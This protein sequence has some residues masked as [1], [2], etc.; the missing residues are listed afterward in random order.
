MHVEHIEQHVSEWDRFLAHSG[1]ATVF[2][3]YRWKAIIEKTFRHACHYFAAVSGSAIT[4][5]LPLVE[6]RSRW[7]GRMAVSMPFVPYGGIVADDLESAAALAD[8]AIELAFRSGDQSLEL[9]QYTAGGLSW[10]R[11]EHKVGLAIALPQD[12]DPY[13]KSLS[14]R[15]RGKVR[16]AQRTGAS[17]AAAGAEGV[18]P[19][20]SVFA[21]NMRDLGT[22]VYPRGLFENAAEAFGSDCRVFLVSLGSRPVAA[23]FGLT[24]YG[25]LQLPWI[26]SDYRYST[27][28]V[29]EYLYW[30]ILEWA[31]GEKLSKVDLGRCTAGGGN[32]RYKQQWN[33]EE[34]QLSWCCRTLEPG[35]AAD[36]SPENPRYRLAIRCWRKLPLPIANAIGPSIVRNLP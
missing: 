12:L 10:P 35:P 3:D 27:S 1:S 18:R 30:S 4:G 33:P 5:V 15:L 23:A 8:A 7:F 2:H 24:G 36:L 14:S 28:Y 16:K 13:W 6:I 11:R 26:C 32:H 29:N 9:R 34:R 21:R 17:F 25:V 19:F 20:Y 22:P 31:H